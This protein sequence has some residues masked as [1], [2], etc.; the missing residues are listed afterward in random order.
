MNGP[1]RFELLEAD[2]GLV[3]RMGSDF[4]AERLDVRGLEPAASGQ[5]AETLARI[6]VSFLLLPHSV[7]PLDDEN[8]ARAYVER[9]IAPIVAARSGT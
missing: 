1:W 8:A 6:F 2:N 4:I 9:C 5:V 3:F 7:V